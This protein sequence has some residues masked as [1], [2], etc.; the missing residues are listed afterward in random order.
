MALVDS[1]DGID[2]QVLYLYRCRSDT[3]WERICQTGL[4]LYDTVF[5]FVL[6]VCRY[7]I[8]FESW[9]PNELLRRTTHF[10]FCSDTC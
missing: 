6:V 2:H 10:V 4:P 9:R 5:P 8:A 7:C 1:V 3:N